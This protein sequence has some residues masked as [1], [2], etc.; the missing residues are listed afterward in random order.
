MPT[1]DAREV[2]VFGALIEKDRST[3]EYYPVTPN[4]IAT[5]CN[6]KINLSKALRVE[7]KIT[8]SD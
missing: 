5:A 4:S 8:G 1:S 3:P 6:Q 7:L 2:H